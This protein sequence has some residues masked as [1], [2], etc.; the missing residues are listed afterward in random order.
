MDTAC[1]S[2]DPSETEHSYQ[3]NSKKVYLIRNFLQGCIQ[4]VIEPQWFAGKNQRLEAEVL[5][6]PLC[7]RR[8]E[9]VARIGKKKVMLRGL[10]RNETQPKVGS[11]GV[12]QVNQYPDFTYLP[13]FSFLPGHPVVQTQLQMEKRVP[14]NV[15]HEGQPLKT[16]VSRFG[17]GDWTIYSIVLNNPTN[18]LGYYL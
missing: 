14:I 5:T 16:R 8:Q 18:S 13:H 3:D 15:F 1:I 17:G 9:G 6:P 12:S 11:Q 7:T 10:P 2:Q 4:D